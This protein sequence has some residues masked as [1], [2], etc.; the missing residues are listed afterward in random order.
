MRKLCS[1]KCKFIVIIISDIENEPMFENQYS[2][3]N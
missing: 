1:K 2:V 3:K